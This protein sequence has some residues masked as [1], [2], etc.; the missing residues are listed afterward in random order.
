[1]PLTSDVDIL[2]TLAA[3]GAELVSLHLMESPALAKS[4]THYPLSGPDTVEAGHPKYL[5][6]GDPEPGTGEPL[7]EGRVYISKDDSKTGKKG[8]YFGGVPQEVWQ[9]QVGGYQV[10]EKW[11]K[12]RRRRPLDYDDK[13]H[14]ERIVVALKETIRLMEEIDAAIPSWPLE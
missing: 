14:Y 11:L 13:T 6:P 5:A 10:C 3:R 4:I 12:D 1:M 7:K 2:R 8:Q 9:F